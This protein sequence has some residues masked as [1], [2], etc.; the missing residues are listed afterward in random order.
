MRMLRVCFASMALLAVT[1]PV[2]AVSLTLV[3]GTSHSPLSGFDL[4]SSVPSV[5]DGQ[6]ITYCKKGPG[7]CGL[8]MSGPAKVTFTYLGKEAGH[9]NWFVMPKMP[10]NPVFSTASSVIGQTRSFIF[11]AFPGGSFLPFLFK[12]IVTGT[13][14]QNG[15]PKN[16]SFQNAIGYRILSATSAYLLFNDAG[17]DRDFDDMAVKVSISAVPLPAALPLFATLLAGL[18]GLAWRR[19]TGA[20]AA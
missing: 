14:A 17:S 2:G 7:P 11:S 12:D 9:T 15:H 18:G 16:A 20:V 3:G 1:L 5:A 13:K 6:S 8:T 4:N 10:G 19:K